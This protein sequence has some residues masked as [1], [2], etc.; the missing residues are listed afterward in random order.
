M[1]DLVRSRGLGDVYKRQVQFVGRDIARVS[2]L[3]HI[4]A[5]ELVRFSGNY[6]GLVFNIDP[7]EIGVIL[8]DPSE[9]IQVGSEVQRT[10]RVLD[11]PVGD[12]LLGRVVDPLGRP[13][14]GLGEVNTV[15]RLPRERPAAEVK[16]R[17][18]AGRYEH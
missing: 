15:M 8:L 18:Q 4:R 13:L 11:V 10:K 14:D 2:G 1:R 12:G 5:E 9:N 3:P 7:K 17:R 16:D 6:M